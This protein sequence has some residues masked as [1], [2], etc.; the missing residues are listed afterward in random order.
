MRGREREWWRM[1]NDRNGGMR[2]SIRERGRIVLYRAWLARGLALG[3]EQAR[4]ISRLKHPRRN[5]HLFLFAVT[6][7]DAREIR[8]FCMN[9]YIPPSRINS[10]QRKK[11]VKMGTHLPAIDINRK[12]PQIHSPRSALRLILIDPSRPHRIFLPRSVNFDV[13]TLRTAY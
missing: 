11:W 4:W 5:E 1:N 3:V 8:A 2:K 9:I 13:F 12:R 6:K 7:R 10:T